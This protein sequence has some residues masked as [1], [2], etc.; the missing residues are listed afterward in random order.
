MG[1]AF[2]RE[3]DR[4]QLFLEAA[5]EAIQN[6]LTLLAGCV[7]GAGGWG[8]TWCA[9]QTWDRLIDQDEGGCVNRGCFRGTQDEVAWQSLLGTHLRRGKRAGGWWWQ[10]PAGWRCAAELPGGPGRQVGCALWG[11]IYISMCLFFH[12]AHCLNNSVFQSG[13]GDGGG[14]GD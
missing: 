7:G 1:Y 10:G 2:L 14:G 9:W 5:K 11:Q 12:R 8:S 13:G 4:K 6:G 3:G